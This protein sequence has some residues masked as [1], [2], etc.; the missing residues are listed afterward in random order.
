M[1]KICEIGSLKDSLVQFLHTKVQKFFDKTIK[2]SRFYNDFK[3]FLQLL[4]NYIFWGDENVH[5]A[6]NV[7]YF[8]FANSF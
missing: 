6:S 2:N 5:T 4:K 3:Y 7:D 8:W 1:E